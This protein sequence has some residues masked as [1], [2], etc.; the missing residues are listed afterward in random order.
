MLFFMKSSAL[1]LALLL[2]VFFV[3]PAPAL[4]A[5]SSASWVFIDPESGEPR[6]DI[7]YELHDEGTQAVPFNANGYL[8]IDAGLTGY[9]HEAGEVF[10]LPDPENTSTRVPVGPDYD[11]TWEQEGTY[12]IDIYDDLLVPTLSPWQQFLAWLLPSAFAQEEDPYHVYIETIRFTITEGPLPDAPCCSSVLFLPGIK[13]SVLKSGSDTLWPPSAWSDDVERLALTEDGTSVETVVVDGIVETFYGAEVYEGFATYMDTLTDDSGNGTIHEWVP[14]AY[15]WRKPLQETIDEGA[16]WEDEGEIVDLVETVENLASESKTGK[17]TIV[18]HSMGGLLGKALIKKLDE[19]YGEADIVDSFI[20]VGSPQLGTPQGMASLLHGDDE[21]IGWGIVVDASEVRT[22][23]QNIESAYQLLP[24]SRYFEEVGDPIMWF[25]SESSFTEAW[26][27]EWGPYINDFAPYREFVTGLGVSRTD[28]DEGRLL[29]PEILRADLF[30]SVTNSHDIY[31]TYEIPDNIRVVELAGWGRPTVKGI[32]YANGH[33]LGFPP[34]PQQAYEVEYTVEG[35]KTVVY[36]SAISSATDEEYFF[37]LQNYNAL[38][39]TPNFEH[40]D[41]LSAEPVQDVISS[42]LHQGAI[43][44]TDYLLGERPDTSDLPPQLLLITR[45]PVALGAY[46]SEGRFTGIDPTQDLSADV[47][48][49]SE[50][51]PGSTF[52]VYGGDQYLFLPKE[53]SYTLK[54]KGTGSGPTTVETATFSGDQA[55]AIATYTD[56]PTTPD[57]EA[58]FLIDS[59]T[60]AETFIEVSENGI[61]TIVAPDGYV[62]PSGDPTITELLTTLKAKI[63]ALDI[64]PK[65]KTNLLKRIGKIEAKIEKQKEHKSKVLEN[66]EAAIAKKAGKGKIDAASDAEI[67]TLLDELEASIAVFPLDSVLIQQ[68]REKVQNLAVTPKL[69]ANLLKRVDR[70]EKMTGLLL[71]LERLTTVVT[72]KGTQGKIPDADAQALLDLLAEIESGL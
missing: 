1:V 57:T 50:N 35:D 32:T 36:P 54:F 51:I 69:N 11:V 44:E 37:D 70:L 12:E 66:L 49:I 13:G 31:D 5:I 24:S 6:E 4:A 28:P 56:I 27:N 59:E 10:F 58:I 15:D 67:T 26:R 25:D 19:E 61:V 9:H 38:E 21:S 16:F 68:L 14:F 3:A 63:Q 17:V 55:T 42:V 8:T 43:S 22:I 71:S 33:L 2:P 62:P 65:L 45:S 23:G 48:H 64:K 41:L 52:V 7:P 72:N 29:I 47:L 40:K 39:D 46:D 60:P 30:D 53:G 34:V 20:M 18:A